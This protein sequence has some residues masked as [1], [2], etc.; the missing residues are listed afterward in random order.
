MRNMKYEQHMNLADKLELSTI[1]AE[2]KDL[3]A[4]RR[5][6]W[7]RLRQRDRVLRHHREQEHG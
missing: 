6:L 4:R 5:R 3:S 2:Q 7:D 1:L